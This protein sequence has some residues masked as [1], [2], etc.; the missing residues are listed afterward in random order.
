MSPVF[1][2]LILLTHKLTLTL[3]LIFSFALSLT[4]TFTLTLSYWVENVEQFYLKF[5]QYILDLYA[6]WSKKNEMV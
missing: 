1:P 4:F 2:I 5:D 6:V 3:K